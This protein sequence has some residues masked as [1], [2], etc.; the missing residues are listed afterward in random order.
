LTPG[1]VWLRKKTMDL[2]TSESEEH[3]HGVGAGVNTTLL[4]DT[5]KSI[6]LAESTEIFIYYNS[7]KREVQIRPIYECRS[8]E[9]PKTQVEESTRLVYTV[10]G[11]VS[12]GTGTPK[13]KDD[14]NRRDRYEMLPSVMGEYS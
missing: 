13:D 3:D 9:R 6:S 1:Q 7:R 12:R 14:I 8:D 10:T 5:L 4:S 11:F 2:C